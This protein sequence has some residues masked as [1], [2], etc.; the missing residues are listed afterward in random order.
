MSLPMPNL[1][2]RRF[3]DLVDEAKRHVQRRAPEWTDHNVS[4]PGVTLIE[5]FAHMV[6]QLVYRLNRVPEKNYLA[7]LELLGIR[8]FPPAAA[9]ADVTFWLSAAQAEVVLLPRGTEVATARS[10]TGD[11]V[12]FA[13]TEE[14][15]IVPCELTAL[16]TISA[17]GEQANRTDDL[18]ANEDVPCF[19]PEPAV[20]DAMLL[21]LSNAVPRCVVVLRLDSQVEGIGVDPRQPPLVWESWDGV[22]WT[23]CQVFD[24]TTGGLNRPGEVVVHV[25][26]GH[27]PSVVAGARA[28]WLRCRVVAPEEGQP[29][30]SESPTVRVAEAFTIGGITAVE[31]AETVT[32]APL[33]VSAGVA[34]QRFRLD[35]APVL[36]DGEPVVVQV[37]DGE[38]WEDWHVVEHFG[39]SGPTDRHVTL[40]P[41]NG[42]FGFPPAVRDADGT[43]RRYGAVPARGAQIRV[44]SY[45]TGGGRAGNVARGAISVLRS[46][47]PYITDVENR[48]AAAG[49]VDGETVDEAKVR[50]PHQLRVQ[51][52]AVTAEDY[53]LIA[54][55]AA[56]AAARI[57]CLPA[58]ARNEPGAARVLVVPDAV[59]DVG[60]QIRFE[61]LIPAEQMLAAIAARLD[62][63]RLL[64]TRLIVEPPFYQGIT[65]VA[66]MRA[67]RSDPTRVRRDTLDALYGYLNPLRGGIDG[68]GWPFGRPVQLGEVY[69]VLQRVEG[70][71][72]I[73][74]V[75]LFPADP[76]TGQ[77]GAPV[78]RVELAAHALVFS[79][80][81][82]VLVQP[83]GAAEG[84]AP[85]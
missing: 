10:E 64:G 83:D 37:A 14:L 18:Q 74:E 56:P 48:E 25:P 39:D 33:G 35:R 15:P 42:E 53:E 79:H 68:T 8:L 12:V 9:R 50:A 32:D 36:T 17:S 41:T 84:G 24:D 16:V 28:G 55:Q 31:H 65:V 78:D 60:D 21:G 26:A 85:R 72:L 73:D 82:L 20:G 61:Q 30:Y 7:F 13:T 44:P 40:D 58:G 34:G 75:R 76:I 81:H 1:D 57:H 62:E 3:Q 23:E 69:A 2:D 49:G 66:R 80:Q 19:Q 22:G 6:D 59:A 45:R 71:E 47:V 43:L 4:D 54:R 38:G 67:G 27:A 63:R 11:A 46:S 52:R 77:R 5:T 51:E 70:V 29:F